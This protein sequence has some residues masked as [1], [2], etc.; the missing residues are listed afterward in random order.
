MKKNEEIVADNQAALEQL[1]TNQVALKEMID[2]LGARVAGLVADIENVGKVVEQHSV[3]LEA[4]KAE[5]TYL[6]RTD[7]AKSDSDR[8]Y[9]LLVDVYLRT[10]KKPVH[11]SQ[12][13]EEVEESGEGLQGIPPILK[14]QFV[15]NIYH[16]DYRVAKLEE[17]FFRPE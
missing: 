8:L 7:D 12:V 5:D 16:R 9:N 2:K 15:R 14:A 11:I 1:G 6:K 10:G 3:R 13:L 17:D 4:L